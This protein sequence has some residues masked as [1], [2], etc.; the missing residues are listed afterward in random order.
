MMKP[1]ELP[2][3][4]EC[5]GERRGSW[6]IF[7]CADCHYERRVNWETGE[8]KV[9]RAGDPEAAHRGFFYPPALQPEH[10]QPN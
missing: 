10:Y 9:T 3:K 4:H 6:I 2:K 8:M 7:R 1:I 5:E